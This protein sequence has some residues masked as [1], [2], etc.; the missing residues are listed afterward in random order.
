MPCWSVRRV[1]QQLAAFV[2]YPSLMADAVKLLGGTVRQTGKDGTAFS[3]VLNGT[4]FTISEG[5]LT[6]RADETEAAELATQFN[7][8]YFMASAKKSAADKGFEFVKTSATTFGLRAP[9]GFGF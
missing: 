7:N 1:S 2:K 5:Q 4:E 9:Q 6:T 3:A 8:A